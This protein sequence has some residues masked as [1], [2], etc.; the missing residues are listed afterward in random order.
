MKAQQFELDLPEYRVERS[1]SGNTML[2]DREN[3]GRI[4]IRDAVQ[5]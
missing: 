1:K 5:F 4:P 3:V 2:I